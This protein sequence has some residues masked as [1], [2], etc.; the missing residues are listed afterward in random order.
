VQT[1]LETA[2]ASTQTI[3]DTYRCSSYLQHM[4]RPCKR[5]GGPSI[6]IQQ[7]AY[8]MK[9]ARRCRPRHVPAPSQAE[10]P[11]LFRWFGANIT[12]A[13]LRPRPVD[14][15]WIV[16]YKLLS[17]RIFVHQKDRAAI[18]DNVTCSRYEP[19]LCRRMWCTRWMPDPPLRLSQSHWAV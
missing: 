4:L 1:C 6:G 12:R 14:I 19:A 8:D 17:G 5:A 18:L 15:S 7:S 3:D 11:Q 13:M 2:L 9:R 16:R 10:G